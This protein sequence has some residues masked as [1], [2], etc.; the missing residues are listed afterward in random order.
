MTIFTTIM[1]ICMLP[2]TGI[3][4]GAQPITSFNYGAGRMDRVGENFKL[5]F[6]CCMIFSTCLWLVI[7]VFPRGVVSIFASDASLIS[8]AEENVRIYGATLF[9]MGIQLACQNM[10]LA[11]GNAKIS[12][13][14]ALL[15]K[16]IL[17]I[18]LIF[19][20]PSIFPWKVQAVFLAEPIADFLAASSTLILF[21][22]TYKNKI[23]I[24]S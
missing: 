18:P 14:L 20:L 10:F 21:L 23:F 3:C 5:L 6:K 7:M 12:L 19:I 8:Y 4:Q 1:Q 11:L 22:K 17:L 24:K 15:R 16:I 13:F 9:I 2:L